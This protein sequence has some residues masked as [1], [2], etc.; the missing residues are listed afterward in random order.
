MAV[1][2]KQFLS[3]GANGIPI[4]VTGVLPSTAN[5]VHTALSDSTA[6]KVDEIWAWAYVRYGVTADRELAVIWSG[7][8]PT[9]AGANIR[10]FSYV[11]PGNGGLVPIIPGLPLNNGLTVKAY[12]TAADVIGIVGFVNRVT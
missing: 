7:A 12:A 9:A 4:A 2:S 5:T 10:R 3:G 6:G 8:T 1:Y 11:V